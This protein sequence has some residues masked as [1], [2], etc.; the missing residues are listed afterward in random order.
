V[1][2]RTV[3]ALAIA[4]ACAL[5]GPASSTAAGDPFEG[6]RF[7]IDP[8]SNAAR[9]ADEWRVTRPWDAQAMERIAS[10]PA[11]DWFGDWTSPI[12][13]QA[14]ARV[15]KIVRNDALPVLVAYN[16]TKRDCGGYSAGGARSARAYRR[17]IRGFAEGIGDRNAAVV[18]EPDALSALECLGRE[19][20]RKRLELLRGAVRTI[21]ARSDASVYIDAGHSNWNPA[22]VTARRLRRAGVGRARGFALNVSNFRLTDAEI[23]YGKQVA[24]MLGGKH[25]L[26]DTSRNGQGPAP[27]GAWCNPP[28][29][30]L[31]PAPTAATAD[32]LVDAYMWVK[33][34]GESDGTCNGGPPAGA[35]WAEY[36]LGLARRA[37]G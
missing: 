21:E 16:I 18:L 26:I 17:W 33:P 1:F 30:G 28:G 13:A 34:P 3:T 9:Q 4:C 20:R 11:A 29:R 23:A 27:D 2:A 5:A 7:Y 15:S 36:A 6:A 31:G 14:D 12:R 37:R 32:P 10:R 35:W 24:G 25:F 8:D 22:A 19:A